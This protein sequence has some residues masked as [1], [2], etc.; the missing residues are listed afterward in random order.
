MVHAAVKLGQRDEIRADHLDHGVSVLHSALVYNDPHLSDRG[1]PIGL[2][3]E[4]LPQSCP[5][6][7]FIEAVKIM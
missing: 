5:R 3:L 1:Y 6:R 2:A 4:Q 7:R